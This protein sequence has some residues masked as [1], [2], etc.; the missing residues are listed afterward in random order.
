MAPTF[1]AIPTAATTT[2]TRKAMQRQDLEKK[3]LA[4]TND[5]Q[6]WGCSEDVFNVN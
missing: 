4:W 3:P 2:A 5:S 6:P 1:I